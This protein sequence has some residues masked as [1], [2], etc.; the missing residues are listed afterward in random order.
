MALHAGISVAPGRL[1]GAVMKKA[2]GLSITAILLLL[3]AAGSAHAAMPEERLP[4]GDD[5]M[6]MWS[7]QSA[8]CLPGGPEQLQS[9]AVPV[10]LMECSLG[11]RGSKACSIRCN[12]VF[13]FYY[14]DCSVECRDGYYSCCNCDDGAICHCYLDHMEL[15]PIAPRD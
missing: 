9:L 14:S 12:R 3:G 7:G 13:G 8:S 1:E 4:Q 5:L 10:S 11:G 15:W 6:G 2:A